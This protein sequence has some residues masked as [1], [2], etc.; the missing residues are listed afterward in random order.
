MCLEMKNNSVK[1]CDICPIFNDCCLK[2]EY[3]TNIREKRCTVGF[4]NTA[5]NKEEEE[6]LKKV[7]KNFQFLP[8][9]S[10]NWLK[11][12]SNYSKITEFPTFTK[13]VPKNNDDDRGLVLPIEKKYIGFQDK[14]VGTLSFTQLKP[15]I[16]KKKQTLQDYIEFEKCNCDK[17]LLTTKFPIPYS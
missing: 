6:I 11:I 2:D 8:P 4:K 7:N 12:I 9:T 16:D 15:E 14:Y 1:L 17:I 3:I 10:A 13:Y 5:K